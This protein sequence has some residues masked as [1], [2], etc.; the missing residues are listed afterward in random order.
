[1][2]LSMF[3]EEDK[4]DKYIEEKKTENNEYNKAAYIL[5]SKIPHIDDLGLDIII[6]DLTIKHKT[7]S[8]MMLSPLTFL[9]SVQIVWHS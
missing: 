6:R 2:M 1:M 7:T 3:S 5:A 9:V 8:K 4:S